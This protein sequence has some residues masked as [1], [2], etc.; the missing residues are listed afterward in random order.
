[1]RHDKLT[2]DEL[3]D[4]A[5]RGDVEAVAYIL[6]EA[7]YLD[8]TFNFH[9][10]K[11]A[12]KYF[13]YG[14]A[15]LFD[16]LVNDLYIELTKNDFRAIKSFSGNREHSGEHLKRIF[17][18]WLMITASR[19]FNEVRRKYLSK[20]ECNIDKCVVS[21]PAEEYSDE[22]DE[23]IMLREAIAKLG[24]EE[25]RIVLEQ[26]LL[27]GKARRSS[28]VAKALTEWRQRRG[29]MREATEAEVNCI[30]SRAYIELRPILIA[31]GCQ[32]VMHKKVQ[33]KSKS[34]Q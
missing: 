15:E 5:Q 4:Q 19:Y 33:T 3:I 23:Y 30:K 20:P 31:M 29:N 6:L 34:R 8:Y 16:G 32:R 17:F 12:S 28:N 21:V 14:T 10:R 25:Q 13:K 22:K 2:F 9:L 24:K 27:P 7:K 18:S 1:M 26:C 11:V